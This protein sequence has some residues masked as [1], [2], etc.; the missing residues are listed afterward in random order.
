MPHIILE[1]SKAI[2]NFA[3][4]DCF[5]EINNTLSSITEKSSLKTRAYSPVIENIGD[6]KDHLFIALTLKLL[7]KPERTL[8][9]KNKLSNDILNILNQYA[10]KSLSLIKN[11][12]NNNNIKCQIT[13]E[14][15]DLSDS[16]SKIII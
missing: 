13:V 16:Y 7:K 15:L 4:E 12:N 5:T 11:N 6:N 2:T 14:V 9:I 3:Y 1:H 10:E 8:E